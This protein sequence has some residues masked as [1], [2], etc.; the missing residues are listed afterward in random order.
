MKCIKL[1]LLFFLWQIKNHNSTPQSKDIHVH[2]DLKEHASPI[3]EPGLDYAAD[4]EAGVAITDGNNAVLINQGWSRGRG[5]NGGRWN[6]RSRCRSRCGSRC[7][8][9]GRCNNGGGS[10]SRSGS[11][12]GSH[13]RS[14]SG[15]G[16]RS[17]SDNSD[18]G[19]NNDS[20]SDSDGNSNE[21]CDTESLIRFDNIW[22]DS[23]CENL[24]NALFGYTLCKCM[25]HCQDN[26]DRGC[27]AFNYWK[28]DAIC[29]LRACKTPVPKPKGSYKG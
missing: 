10:R 18:S 4:E 11:R 17:G 15:S 29:I 16:S 12:S 8:N 26:E 28:G 22:E 23:Q 25:S 1:L 9:R 14:G 5:G 3:V 13:G 19:S 21:D 6:A 7:R 27:T 20:G 24:D 2:V